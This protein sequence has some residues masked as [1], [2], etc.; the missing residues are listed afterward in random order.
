MTNYAYSAFY[1]SVYAV[2]E[3]SSLDAV[4]SWSKHKKS[5]II[6]DPIEFQ[7]RVMP[8]GRQKRILCLNFPMFIDDL[9]YYGFVRVKGSKHRY[10]FGHPKYFVKG[11]PELMTKMYEEAHEKRMHKF[12]Q[13]RAMRKAMRKK[14]EAR[15]MELSGA[16]GDLAL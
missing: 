10:H 5:F 9:K 3:D 2:V 1:K 12:Q 4:V 7:R 8:T 14:A 6:W 13:A 16:L 11:K 15:A